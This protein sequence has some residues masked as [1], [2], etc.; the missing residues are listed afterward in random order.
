MPKAADT[1]TTATTLDVPRTLRHSDTDE[2]WRERSVANKIH[3]TAVDAAHRLRGCAT[4]PV[5]SRPEFA[6]L[7]SSVND[8]ALALERATDAQL[9]E[10]NAE[11][12]Q[13][14]LPKPRKPGRG[15]AVA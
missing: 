3:V 12:P 6:F 9:A 14:A 1:H 4:T 8:I 15:R 11:T 13:Q 5:H 10:W 2:Q 7:A